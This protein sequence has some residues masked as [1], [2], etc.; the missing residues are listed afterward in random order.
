MIENVVGHLPVILMNS[1]FFVEQGGG[2]VLQRVEQIGSCP[3]KDRHEIVSY[4]FDAELCQIAKRGL[5]VFN[6][7]VAGGETD[8]DIVMDIDAFHHVHVEA[9]AL[10]TASD[11]F[12]FLRFPY[13]TCLFVVE[14]PDESG[15]SGNLPDHLRRDAVVAVAVPAKCHLHKVTSWFYIEYSLKLSYY[16]PVFPIAQVRKPRRS[17]AAPP[18]F[19][20]DFP[21]TVTHI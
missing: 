18:S 15:D 4:D 21:K 9:G 3:V 19:R 2:A 14:R 7:P 17:P 16:L 10:N 13:L 8:F 6:I 1:V 12:Y 20:P 5:I 11:G